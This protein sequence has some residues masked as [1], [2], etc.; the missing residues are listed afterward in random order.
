[1]AF[2]FKCFCTN[3]IQID[4]IKSLWFLFK[5]THL[6]FKFYLLSIQSCFLKHPFV[7]I[8]YTLCVHWGRPILNGPHRLLFEELS[9]VVYSVF[10]S[11]LYKVIIK[12]FYIHYFLPQKNTI[13]LLVY[14]WI[15]VCLCTVYKWT[16]FIWAIIIVLSPNLFFIDNSRKTK[17]SVK[18]FNALTKIAL[19]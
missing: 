15:L 8:G 9:V 14:Q 12:T 7:N 11:F 3:K 1:M 18:T 19:L 2:H 17:I 6:G 5:C 4:K 16:L 13:T 10:Q